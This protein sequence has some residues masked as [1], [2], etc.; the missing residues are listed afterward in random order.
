MKTHLQVCSNKID[1]QRRKE[2]NSD[3]RCQQTTAEKGYCF[4]IM[5]YS[6]TDSG[7]IKKETEGFWALISS[8]V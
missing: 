4:F 5:F 2:A 8:N 1:Q 7:F 6:F 3:T